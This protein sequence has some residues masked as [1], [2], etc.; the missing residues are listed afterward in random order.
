MGTNGKA[1]SSNSG[2]IVRQVRLRGLS[3]IMFDPY[4]GDNKTQLQ[5]NQKFYFDSDGKS[6]VIPAANIHSFLCATNTRSAVKAFYDMRRYKDVAAALLG[7]VSISPFMIPLTD[8]ERQIEFNGFDG[9]RF[10]LHNSVARLP[11]GIPNPKSRPVVSTP[12]QLEFELSIFKNDVV[13]EI[14]VKNLIGK[15]GIAIGLG[16]YRGVYGKFAVDMWE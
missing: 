7:F 2:V 13:S 11:K 5:P 4:A 12:W 16:T 6:L 3:P 1:G 9:K 14:E 15:G 10:I 8:G